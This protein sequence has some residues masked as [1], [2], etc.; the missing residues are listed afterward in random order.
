MQRLGVSYA[1]G[2]RVRRTAIA[3]RFRKACRRLPR[4][5]RLVKAAR[6]SGSRLC[7]G[8]VLPAAVYGC[9]VTGASPAQCRTLSAAAAEALGYPRRMG[10]DPVFWAS[11][12]KG[13]TEWPLMCLTVAPTVRYAREWW[14]TTDFAL[15]HADTLTPPQLLHAFDSELAA[16]DG[17]DSVST[18]SPIALAIR[19]ASQS[20]FRFDGPNS[21]A[22][23]HVRFSFARSSPA[24]IRDVLCYGFM[25]SALSS[26]VVRIVARNP[27]QRAQSQCQLCHRHT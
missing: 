12:S 5:R 25:D 9:D 2:K 11:I 19:G 27:K 3:N 10:N 24:W 26:Y 17:R 7:Y 20:G 6:Q 1:S 15:R 18:S 8:G 22:N 4:L 16:Y 21:I 14:M 23:D 13:G